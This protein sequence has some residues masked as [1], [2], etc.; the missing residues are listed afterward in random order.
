[1]LVIPR[2]EASLLAVKA[3]RDLAL[4]EDHSVVI[5]QHRQQNPALEIR[6]DC[7]PV[8]IEIGGDMASPDPIRGHR[9]TRRCRFRSPMW[10]GTKSRISP[11]PWAC[12]A[13]ISARKSASRAD[14]RVEPVVVDDVVAVRRA[15]ARLHDRRRI[16]VADPESGEVRHQ[17]SGVAKREPAMELQAIGGADRGEAVRSSRSSGGRAPPRL[18]D[19]RCDP[20]QL[21]AADDAPRACT[22]KRRRQLGCASVVPG[23]IGLLDLAEHVLELNQHRVERANGAR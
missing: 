2:A 1:M 5:A 6:P 12:S 17:G 7:V 13:S 3:Q 4:F 22:D 11:M 15:G 10:F 9:A 19:Q 14:F 21:A 18:L 20:A 23:Q 8:D 16:D